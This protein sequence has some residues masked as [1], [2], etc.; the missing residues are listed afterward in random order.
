MDSVKSLTGGVKIGAKPD[1]NTTCQPNFFRTV[2][3][4]SYDRDEPGYIVE[5]ELA[6]H[7]TGQLEWLPTDRFAKSDPDW[8]RS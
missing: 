1:L 5:D 8:D 2:A 6:G 3:P 4:R 7:W